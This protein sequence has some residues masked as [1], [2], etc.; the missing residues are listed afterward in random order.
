[1]RVRLDETTLKGIANMTGGA[2]YQAAGAANLSEIYREL[3][4]KLVMEKNNFEISALFTALA[5]ALVLAS[6][7]LSFAWFHRVF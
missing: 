4:I 6:A 1:M 2:Y 3:S 7:L 5:A